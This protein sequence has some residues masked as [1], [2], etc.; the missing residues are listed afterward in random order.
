LS[1]EAI[2]HEILRD[3]ETPVRRFDP[4]ST[5]PFVNKSISEA[6]RRAYSRTVREFFQFVGMRHPSEIVP[7]DLLLWRDWLRSQKKSAATVSFKL[8]VIRSFFES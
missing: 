2:T 6:T 1:T 4:K 5:T 7:N 8:S 3:G